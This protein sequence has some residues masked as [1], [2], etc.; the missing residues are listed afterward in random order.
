MTVSR[1]GPIDGLCGIAVLIVFM[2]HTAGRGMYLHPALNFEGIGHIG[3]YL[4]FCLSAFLLASK[5]FDEGV[6]LKSAKRFYIKRFFRI[7]PLYFLVVISV[8]IA[9]YFFGHYNESYLHIKN[10]TKGFIQHLALYRGDGVFWSVVVEEQFYILVP[11]WIYIFIR[12]RTWAVIAFGGLALL[13]FLLY[14]SKYL[15]WPLSVNWIKYMTT[16]DRDSG[17]YIDIFI[18]TIIMLYFFHYNKA[19]FEKNKKALA[20]LANILFFGLMIISMIVMSERFI[21]FNKPFYNFRYISLLYTGVF[22]LFILSVSLENPV[23]RMLNMKW[24]RYIGMYGFSIYLLHMLIFELVNLTQV[25]S[26]FK[27]ILGGTGIFI[28]SAVTYN[29]IEMPAIKFSYK[30]IDRLKIGK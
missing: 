12:F 18:G 2:S 6:D 23:N 1:F 15:H 21:M 19:V 27:F 5:L 22:S 30:L 4:F 11:L 28:L 29:L 26:Y 8:F 13:N 16:N 14:T 10:G 25:A 24:L 20:I 3:V 9:Q 7:I 17:N